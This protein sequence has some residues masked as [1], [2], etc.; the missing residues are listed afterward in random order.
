M[1]VRQ[2][3]ELKARLCYTNAKIYIKL[4]NEDREETQSNS[5]TNGI[6]EVSLELDETKF[7]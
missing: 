3:T 4:L 2:E 7:F 5:T 1:S 6:D